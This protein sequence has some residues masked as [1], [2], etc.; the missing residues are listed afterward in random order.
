MHILGNKLTGKILSEIIKLHLLLCTLK[1]DADI[2]QILHLKPQG[3]LL[4]IWS[5]FGYFS[6]EKKRQYFIT[7]NISQ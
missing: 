6:A 5:C 7:T 3:S 2:Q 1:V 4:L